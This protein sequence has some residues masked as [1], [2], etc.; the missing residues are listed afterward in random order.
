[1]WVDGIFLYSPHCLSLSPLTAVQ[2]RSRRIEI[3]M[4]TYYDGEKETIIHVTMSKRTRAGEDWREA[5]W[6][7]D[8]DCGENG[9]PVQRGLKRTAEVWVQPH[10][11]PHA[12]TDGKRGVQRWSS[13]SGRGRQAINQHKSLTPSVR[14]SFRRTT[15]RTSFQVYP[16]QV[17]LS[18]PTFDTLT[19]PPLSSLPF[20][21]HHLTLHR[22]K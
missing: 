16:C 21:S 8:D 13:K 3:G 14:P 4:R 1:M 17:S 7:G 15:G 18:A 12:G 20:T 5:K 19:L 2:G 11:R 22:G 6:G 10:T 9:R